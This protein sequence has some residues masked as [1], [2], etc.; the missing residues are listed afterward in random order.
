MTDIIFTSPLQIRLYELFD[1]YVVSKFDKS[2]QS[3][4]KIELQRR[5]LAVTPDEISLILSDTDES[6]KCYEELYDDLVYPFLVNQEYLNEHLDSDTD[7][8]LFRDRYMSVINTTKINNNYC[9][10]HMCK[11][12]FVSYNHYATM[13]PEHNKVYRLED[14]IC[15]CGWVQF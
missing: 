9:D 10:E 3:Y 7:H 12:A 6:A 8:K 2:I 5:L 14:G 13:C 1:Y 15:N 11:C 4:L